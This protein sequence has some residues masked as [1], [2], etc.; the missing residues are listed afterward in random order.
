[1][2]LMIE[3]PKHSPSAF[4]FELHVGLIGNELFWMTM[5]IFLDLD[6]LKQLPDARY[7]SSVWIARDAAVYLPET[8]VLAST[9][10][11]AQRYL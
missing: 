5:Q 11:Y 8:G 4:V 3:R 10:K 2:N 1:M 9:Y 6:M 7:S